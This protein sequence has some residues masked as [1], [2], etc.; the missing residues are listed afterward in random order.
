MHAAIVLQHYLV[1]MNSLSTTTATNVDDNDDDEKPAT[2]LDMGL[3]L[4]QYMD[5]RSLRRHIWD[6]EGGDSANFLRQILVQQPKPVVSAIGN[7]PSV[8]LQNLK[9][10]G[11]LLV[12]GVEV[13]KGFAAKNGQVT[14][15]GQSTGDVLGRHAMGL[16]GHRKTATNEDL[17]LLQN[18]WKHKVKL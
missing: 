5:A 14:F 11:P 13:T 17:F 1:W 18:W 3:Y 16:V 10:F 9:R 12:A 6:D 15:T 8:W 4:R 2:M 7:E